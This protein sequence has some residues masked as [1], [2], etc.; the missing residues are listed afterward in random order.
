METIYKLVSIMF[1]MELLCTI[2]DF[3]CFSWYFSVIQPLAEMNTRNLSGGKGRP[4]RKA[5]N[6]TAIC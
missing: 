3:W 5:D 4:A 6:I 1:I 2:H